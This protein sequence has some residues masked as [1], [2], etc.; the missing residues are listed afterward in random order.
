MSNPR[1][2]INVAENS[3]SEQLR[4]M[5]LSHNNIIEIMNAIQEAVT[6]DK[7]SV[8]FKMTTV[9]GT[10][11]ILHLPTNTSLYNE[12]KILSSNQKQILGLTENGKRA[13]VYQNGVHRNVILSSYDR[14][15]QNWENITK[16]DDVKIL[17][18]ST[19]MNFMNPISSIAFDLPTNILQTDSVYVKKITVS[20]SFIDANKVDFEYN[21][22]VL[23]L[24]QESI[25]FKEYE[26]VYD[27]EPRIQRYYGTFDILK[28]T[29]R[30]NGDVL[31]ELE[32]INYSDIESIALTRELD[33]G[34]FLV[35]KT[36][37]SKFEVIEINKTT[38]NV[39]I[40][41]VGGFDSINIGIGEL[42]L[43][44]DIESE[45]RRLYVPINGN[46]Y[47]YL[48]LAPINVNTSVRTEL[49][50]SYF[51]DSDDLFVIENSSSLPFNAYF[52]Q[53]VQNIGSYLSSLIEESTIPLSLG[54]VPDKPAIESNFFQVVQVN[55]H[56]MDNTDI[57]KVTQLLTE[58]SKTFASIISLDN[59]IRDV[60]DRINAGKYKSPKERSQDVNELQKLS[61][62]HNEKSIYHDS[63]IRD[64]AAKTQNEDL[65][66]LKPKYRIRGFWPV[67]EPI[68]SENS[69]P[70]NIVSY[71]VQYRYLSP[72]KS[73]TN[74]QRIKY[75]DNEKELVGSFTDWNI[76]P[77]VSLKKI[78]DVN[79]NYEWEAVLSEDSDKTNINQL[80]IPIRAGEKVQ[81]RIKAIS[82][83]GYPVSG[84]ESDWSDITTVE[85]PNDLLNTI[86]IIDSV[87]SNF[88]DLK[89]AIIRDLFRSRGIDTHIST[90][91]TERDKYFA[92]HSTQIASGF[93]TTE[94]STISLFDYLTQ[95]QTR[96][97]SLEDSLARRL[98]NLDID[99]IDAST[100]QTYSVQRN[101]TINLFG[102]YYNDS[103]D[104][105][106][107]A[108]F[109]SIV[110][111]MFYLRI[112]NRSAISAELLS[113]SSGVLTAET[114]NNNYNTIG[115]SISDTTVKQRNGQVLYLRKQ[116]I[117]SSI[118]LYSNNF[119]LI[120]TTVPITSIEQ[121]AVVTSHNAV[122]L[123]R[124]GNIESIKIKSD[125]PDIEWV[126]LGINHP[127]V[128]EWKANP[129]PATITK[130][131]NELIRA[132]RYN[133]VHKMKDVQSEFNVNM[134]APYNVNDTHL[135]GYYTSGSKVFLSSN[136]FS[137]FQ[138]SSSDTGAV[139]ELHPGSS[140]ALLIP[141]ILQ[142]RMTDALGR[143]DGVSS[144]SLNDTFTYSKLIGVDMIINNEPFRFDVNIESKFR[145]TTISNHD[146]TIDKVSLVN[147]FNSGNTN[148]SIT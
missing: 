130:I 62:D 20:K 57:K 28:T 117:S 17:S 18:K 99:L 114:T 103:I 109:G 19:V 104:L 121:S 80:D 5:N 77:S 115:V 70:Q 79:G 35:N 44:V 63:L 27:T 112:T 113:S 32:A 73:D 128:I 26:D 126:A 60:Q 76:Y 148:P 102:G 147:N 86:D 47:Q 116:D 30:D 146:L 48:F 16:I 54:I 85:F 89:Q 46:S 135:I 90:S 119:A 120:P 33:T 145:S 65:T 122:H 75:T 50:K 67:Q 72:T 107:P 101:A 123:N 95:Q 29:P 111:K 98:A 94:Q 83:A 1:E 136:S 21:E 6:S 66:T 91:F 15:L 56:L 51:V 71:I 42:T 141:V 64:I 59:S 39:T 7:S 4:Q 36:G 133:A 81:I 93:T 52:N 25:P 110:R 23:K 38:N 9:D 142:F 31:I 24:N 87:K 106:E 55:S 40:R 132:S 139:R 108:S 14:K 125:S 127:F 2:S 118:N 49:S 105:S 61:S 37:T 143:P 84:L 88:D 22:L 74:I 138:V 82:E 43:T 100:N 124:D 144:N 12:L 68:F 134:T 45:K 69:R 137:S 8:E 10:E 131:K 78:K 97:T 129:L 58:K 13:T 41:R 53:K 96:I 3:L 140:N 34:D 11:T 92:H